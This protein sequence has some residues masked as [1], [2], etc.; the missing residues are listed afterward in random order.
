MKCFRLIIGTVHECRPGNM[1]ENLFTLKDG[2]VNSFCIASDYNFSDWQLKP[3]VNR[4][5]CGWHPRYWAEYRLVPV[6]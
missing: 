5:W 3:R 1:P 6:E 4:T 2:E